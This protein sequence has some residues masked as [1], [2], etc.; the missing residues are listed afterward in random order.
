LDCLGCQR[1]H[2]VVLWGWTTSHYRCNGVLNFEGKCRSFLT[3]E[4]K[5]R[6]NAWKKYLICKLMN[7]GCL[8]S[9]C[10]L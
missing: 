1:A 2:G 8:T 6:R 4:I 7:Y 3:M 10:H 9:Y 5:Q